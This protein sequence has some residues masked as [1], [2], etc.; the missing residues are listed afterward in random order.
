MTSLELAKLIEDRLAVAGLT[1]YLDKR[2]EQYLEFPDGFFAEIVLIDG[3]RLDDAKGILRGIKEE[4]ARQGTD[5]DA[6][7][8]ANWEVGEVTHMG[9]APAKSGGYKDAVRFI[10][11]LMSGSREC[12]VAVDISGAAHEEIRRKLSEGSLSEYG[13]SE[14]SALIGIVIEFLRLELS[15]GGESHWDPIQYPQRELN[16]A[17]LLYLTVHGPAKAT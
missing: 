4:L 12:K 17:A 15:L 3:S 6:I 8:R 11:T 1:S 9:L 14:E 2:K 16:G 7:V 10:A 13:R 5:L